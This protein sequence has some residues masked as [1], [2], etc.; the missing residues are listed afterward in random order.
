MH[1]VELV[2]ILEDHYDCVDVSAQLTFDDVVL[3]LMAL[4][5]AVYKRVG[6]ILD[7]LAVG[8][9]FDL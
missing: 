6:Q 7:N 3:V 4:L 8:F 1:L 5:S 2:R 9:E